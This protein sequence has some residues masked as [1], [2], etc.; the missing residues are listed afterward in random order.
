MQR[1]ERTV[2]V[3]KTRKRSYQCLALAEVGRVVAMR[4]KAC[5]YASVPEKRQTLTEKTDRF[6]VRVCVCHLS[7]CSPPFS[8]LVVYVYETKMD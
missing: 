8:S 4:K 1:C 3:D 2:L 6:V 5:L 7:T